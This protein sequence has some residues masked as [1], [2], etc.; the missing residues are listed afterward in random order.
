MPNVSVMSGQF[1]VFLGWT[2]TKQRIKCL[3]V[4]LRDTTV[5]CSGTKCSTSSKSQTSDPSI[6][7]L[8]LYQLRH[9]IPH[10]GVYVSIC[11]CLFVWFDSLHPINNL[12][13][14]KGW[15]FL[16]WTSTKLELMCL[17]QGHNTMTRARLQPA[18]PGSRVK[19]YQWATALSFLGCTSQFVPIKFLKRHL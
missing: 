16:G 9:C 11:F 19:H 15:V 17:A 3:T 14:I 18:P 6:P 7:I 1:P 2:N 4:F 13:V 8:T 10:S 12:S 5:S